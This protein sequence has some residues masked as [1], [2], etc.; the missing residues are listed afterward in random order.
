MGF[1]TKPKQ[2]TLPETRLEQFE[3]EAAAVSAILR[4]VPKRFVPLIEKLLCGQGASAGGRVEE[5]RFRTGKPVQIVTSGGELLLDRYPVF[6]SDE[7]SAMLAELCGHSV[8][9]RER[10]LADGF[11]TL[12]GGARVGLAGK[13]VFENGKLLHFTA[14]SG[15]NIRIPRQVIGCS[16]P[17]MHLLTA[18]GRP[19]SAI[20][21]APPGEGKTTFLRDCARCFSNG[22]GVSRPLTTAVS[23][24]RNELSACAEGIPSLDIGMRTDVIAGVPKAAAIP[25]LVRNMA[26]EVIVTDELLGEED[27]RAFLNA[28]AYGCAVLA[29]IHAGSVR[30]LAAKRWLNDASDRVKV[31]LLKRISDRF[32]LREAEL[33]SVLQC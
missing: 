12:P 19:A 10:E 26:P 24:E 1:I 6:T 23:D 25:M 29:S 7:A 27:M 18:G 16:E 22:V 15:F 4:A 11:I 33:A 17:F 32:I 14:V 5:L 9:A 31:F 28:C 30:D 20:I 3:C 8:Y 13:P 2:D 21:A